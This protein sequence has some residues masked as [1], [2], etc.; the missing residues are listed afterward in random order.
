MTAP[1]DKARVWQ[2]PLFSAAL[3]TGLVWVLVR[4]PPG[5]MIRA[6]PWLLLAGAF[7]YA[8]RGAIDK[9]GI[10]EVLRAWRGGAS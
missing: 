7:L 1:I 10:A 3:I 2:R 5:D 6:L 8:W 4:M 9:G